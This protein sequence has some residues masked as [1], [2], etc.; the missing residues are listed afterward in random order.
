MIANAQRKAVTALQRKKGRKASGCFLVEGTKGVEEALASG[1]EVETVYATDG[2]I[3]PP[4]SR[5]EVV[6]VTDAEMRKLSALDTPPGVLAVVRIPEPPEVDV[7]RG[8]WLGLDGVRDPG[9]LGTL[10]RLADWF[11]L[12][13]VVCSPDCVDWSNP[14]V[15]QA[16]MGSLFRKPPRV[17]DLADALSAAPWSAGAFLDGESLYETPLPSDGLLVLGGES[18]GIRPALEAVLSRRLTIPRFGGAESL[19][20]AMAGAV[21]CGEW[22]RSR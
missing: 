6:R 14:K 22:R 9:N 20:V 17:L 4:V 2:W 1:W 21:F 15:V 19:N 3:P 11:G 5:V 18:H 12:D 8:R 16:A 13:G 7:S 10:L